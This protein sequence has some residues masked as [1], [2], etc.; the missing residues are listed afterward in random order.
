MF[1][2]AESPTDIQ[3]KTA[4]IKLAAFVAE[5]CVSFLAMDHL[6][7]LLKEIFTDSKIAK[8]LSMK[9]TKITA[10]NRN[11]IGET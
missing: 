9:R 5:H 3:I 2:P 8:E 6:N 4:E 11:V 7:D 10:V 1:T